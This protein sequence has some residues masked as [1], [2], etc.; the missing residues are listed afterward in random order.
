M[1]IGA[2]LKRLRPVAIDRRLWW[3]LGVGAALVAAE[4]TLRAWEQHQQLR[5]TLAGVRR[6]IQALQKS[7][8]AVDWAART[9][10][11]RT[12]Y[13]TL[14]SRLW[15][16][17]S[18]AQAQAM[19][20]DWLGSTL[21]S[22]GVQ[23]PTLRLQPVV[24]TPAE[25]APD[26]ED[27]AVAR[28]QAQRLPGRAVRVRAQVGF[29]LAPGT[30]ELVLRHVERGGQLASVDSLSVSRRSRRVDMTVSIPV[31]VRSDGAPAR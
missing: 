25:S 4:L 20:R 1:S 13:A 2:W 5:N 14:E 6:N 8:D 23:R 3:I 12:L 29:E 7:T 17:P 11:L 26:R 19:L 10:E 30:L 27:D 31:V 21:K 24:A 18:E 16:A 28:A 9:D 22:A 15:M